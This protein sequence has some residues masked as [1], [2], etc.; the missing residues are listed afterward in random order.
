MRNPD[1]QWIDPFMKGPDMRRDR[2]RAR[3]DVRVDE[4]V[5][6]EQERLRIEQ[7]QG[8]NG[9]CRNIARNAAAKVIPISVFT[10]T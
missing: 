1:P 9:A 7:A 10:A 3:G 4:F 6:V 2:R 8:V 5:G